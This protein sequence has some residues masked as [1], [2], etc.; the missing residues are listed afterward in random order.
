[1]TAAELSRLAYEASGFCLAVDL[2]LLRKALA[3][4]RAY[5]SL[6]PLAYLAE[7]RHAFGPLVTASPEPGLPAAGHGTAARLAES[8]PEVFG[9][10]S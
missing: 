8:M 9:S 6:G 10:Q 2:L 7:L 5:D 4:R 3:A 1:M